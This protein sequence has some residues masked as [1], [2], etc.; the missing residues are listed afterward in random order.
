VPRFLIYR[1]GLGP[2]QPALINGAGI[3]ERDVGSAAETFLTLARS[4][5]AFGGAAIG[6]ILP[7]NGAWVLARRII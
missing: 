5:I 7:P 6:D 3:G 4:S 1:I 2:A